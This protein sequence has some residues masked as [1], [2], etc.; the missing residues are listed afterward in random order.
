MITVSLSK[1]QI[2]SLACSVAEPLPLFGG[3]GSETFHLAVP[4]P[5]LAPAT[6]TYRY[7][8]TN[9]KSPPRLSLPLSAPYIRHYS[10]NSSSTDTFISISVLSPLFLFVSPFLP[11]S[12]SPL[13]FNPCSL[14]CGSNLDPNTE[15]INF[16]KK[17]KTV[18]EEKDILWKKSYFK[19]YE[20]NGICRNLK[21]VKS[22]NRDFMS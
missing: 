20:N 2:F 12:A 6:A 5:A 10:L 11:L 16:S 1:S 17:V 4:A 3:F 8:K 15:F 22:L 21:S 7:Y 14:C 13:V 9:L 19:L 18:L